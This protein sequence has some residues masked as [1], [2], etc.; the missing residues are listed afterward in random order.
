VKP[1]VIIKGYKRHLS[2][3]LEFIGFTGFTRLP[4]G[5]I[6]VSYRFHRFHTPGG[7]MR[8]DM[9]RSWASVVRKLLPHRDAP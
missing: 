5:F 3:S 6:A 1:V 2:F 4:C 7:E 9:Q 8:R